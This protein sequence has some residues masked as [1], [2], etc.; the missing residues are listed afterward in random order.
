MEL[1][2]VAYVRFTLASLIVIYGGWPFVRNASG[3]LRRR[4]PGMM[5]LIALATSV[6]YVHSTAVTFGVAGTV[7]FLELATLIDVMLLGHWI[8]MRSILGASG[9]LEELVELLP[10]EAHRSIN[11][12]IEDVPLRALQPSD[13]VL[14]R[15]GERI[16]VDGV[17]I[18]GRTS[19][20]ESMVIGE[21]VPVE[22]SADDEVIGGTVNGAAAITVEVRKTGSETY[23]SQVVNMVREARAARATSS[24]FSSWHDGPAARWSKTSGGP[25]D[26]TSSPSRWPPGRWVH[27]GSFSRLPSE[28]L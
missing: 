8:E 22:R 17:I 13:R 10:A 2:W 3:E 25:P 9:A 11:D 16:P 1:S 19:I 4:Q 23:L 6:A 12:D 20:D 5:T 14:V 28:R 7:F 24:G 27:G 18:D 26:T 21:S 15:P